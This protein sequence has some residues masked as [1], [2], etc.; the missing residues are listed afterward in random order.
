MVIHNLTCTYDASFSREFQKHLSNAACNNGVI[1][2]G[3][4]KKITIIRTWIERE[5]H[6]QEDADVAHKDVNMLQNIVYTCLDVVAVKYVHDIPKIICN[7]NY[8]KQSL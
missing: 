8:A 5:Y 6:I 2:Q 7:R 3:K 4:Y 1:D